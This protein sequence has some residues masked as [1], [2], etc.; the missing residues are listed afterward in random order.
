MGSGFRVGLGIG[1]GWVGLLATEPMMT[2]E[3]GRLE[4]LPAAEL[5]GCT[6][7]CRFLEPVPVTIL[8]FG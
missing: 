5:A 7:R 3:Q 1:S 8:G 4:L 2:A 6:A